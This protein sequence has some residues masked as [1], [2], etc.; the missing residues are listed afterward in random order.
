MS[1]TISRGAKKF[2]GRFR[3]PAPPRVTNMF[4]IL[5]WIFY[6]LSKS[7]NPLNAQANMPVSISNIVPRFEKVMKR[8]QEEKSH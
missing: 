8:N 4:I 3:P 6:F 5:L 2:V 7:K 1:K